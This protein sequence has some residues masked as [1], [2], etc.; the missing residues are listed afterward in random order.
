MFGLVGGVVVTGVIADG[1]G[2]LDDGQVVEG[3]EEGAEEGA[4]GFGDEPAVEE[5]LAR[6]G[7][8]EAGR[9]LG[10]ARFGEDGGLEGIEGVAGDDLERGDDFVAGRATRFR[11]GAFEEV[12]GEGRVLD[13]LLQVFTDVVAVAAD[14]VEVHDG[15]VAGAAG[16]QAHGDVVK[17]DSLGANSG[18]GVLLGNVIR[19]GETGGEDG[20]FGVVEEGGLVGYDFVLGGV[21]VGV[22]EAEPNGRFFSWLGGEEVGA[23][24]T[25]L[26]GLAV[27][28]VDAAVGEVG[29]GGSTVTSV[30][31]GLEGCDEVAVGIGSMPVGGVHLAEGPCGTGGS[32]GGFQ[33]FLLGGH[34]E[35][36]IVGDYE[37][38]RVVCAGLRVIVDAG[39]SF[40]P[41][42][43]EDREEVFTHFLKNPAEG[44]GHL[45][46]PS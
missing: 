5:L 38:R 11:V 9:L 26:D 37:V 8:G 1:G 30:R 25:D 4:V 44:C 15:Q 43:I 23:T 40:T 20:E 39:H 34:G 10:L 33:Q 24:E 18:G 14:K 12:E 42:G 16:A 31:E 17:E 27:E 6:G 3:A 21:L 32:L 29:G 36:R 28:G 46:L 7:I 35:L 19:Q 2:V 22:E 45:P 13:R 41:Y